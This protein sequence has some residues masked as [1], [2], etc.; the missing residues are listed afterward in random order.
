VAPTID[1]RMELEPNFPR[2]SFDMNLNEVARR[3]QRPSPANKTYTPVIGTSL[4]SAGALTANALLA[5]GSFPNQ[6]IG[7]VANSMSLSNFLEDDALST[8]NFMS[9]GAEGFLRGVEPGFLPF[10]S[11]S[12]HCPN[13]RQ[14]LI[15][16]SSDALSQHYPDL[17]TPEGAYLL[18]HNYKYSDIALPECR[19]E[20]PGLDPSDCQ[21]L[22]YA[23]VQFVSL[24]QD[25]LDEYNVTS[26]LDYTCS[27]LDG[28]EIGYTHLDSNA[29][30][31]V[32]C[33]YS[34][35]QDDIGNHNFCIRPEV[36]T[37]HSSDR[38]LSSPSSRANTQTTDEEHECLIRVNIDSRNLLPSRPTLTFDDHIVNFDLNS[39]PPSSKRKRNS[40]TRAEREKVRLVRDWGA[41]VFCRSR[42]VSVRFY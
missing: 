14:M 35:A 12:S 9:V 27:D 2:L 21:V 1:E 6:F 32:D 5:N 37:L 18:Q 26:C 34:N 8:N 15:T 3:P 30:P 36:L 19:R 38:H 39:K 20:Q 17:I 13:W 22:D 29:N 11:D 10:E 23:D 16:S 25:A 28:T 41:C 42:K 33:H 40:F 24:L 4:E 31:L 7:D